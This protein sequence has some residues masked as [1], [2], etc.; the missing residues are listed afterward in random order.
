MNREF[1][2]RSAGEL[3]GIVKRQKW[4]ILLPVLTFT[5]AIGYVVYHLP[6]IY[7]S[8][9]LLTVKPPTISQTLVQALSNEDLSQRL[10][11][12][13]Q[14]V[15]SR[16]SLEPMVTKYDLYKQERASGMPMELIIEKM[17]KA[18]KVDIEDAGNEKVASFR[19]RYRDRDPQATRNVTAE[20]ASKYVNAQVQTQTEIAESTKDL[21]EKQLG[22]KKAAMDDLERQRLDIMTANVATLPESEQGLVAQLSGLRDREANIMKEK[23]SLMNERGRLS[24]SIGSNNRQMALIEDFGQRATNDS[25]RSAAD[26]ENS[27]A[28]GELI[29]KRADINASLDNL[30]KTYKDKHPLV[31]AKQ[32]E[33]LRI[34]EEFENL[35]KSADKRVAVATSTSKDRVDMQKKA[36]ELENQRIQSQIGQIETQLGNKDVEIRQNA[37]EVAALEARINA[38]PGVKVA[39]EGI[40]GQY[41]FAKQ[42]Y[43]EILK[44][45]NEAET[46][47]GVE[48]NAQG[49]TIRVQ[50]PANVPQ[51]PVAP[52]RL[53]WTLMGSALGLFIGLLL[54]GIFE[55]PRFFKIQNIE[56][57]R[58]YTGLPV[59]ASVPPL[60]S[61]AEKSWINRSY[62]MRLGAG[63]AASLGVIPLIIFILQT[64]RLLDRFV[65]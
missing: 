54:A 61:P 58:H 3:I 48:T 40:N 59:L 11:T 42:T 43:D 35:R 26:P 19:I 24:D 22:E 25:A 17:Y 10:Q 53:V 47:V 62:W 12:I 34:N 41:Q 7:E 18:I 50:D 56:D 33:L 8:T 37:A 9:S 38:V 30:L 36:L 29:K 64:T 60:L 55:I 27:V 14:E 49:E 52:K 5:A 13:N 46:V 51:S 57:A 39:L 4:M 2:Q 32:A 65:A 21:F 23:E 28:W 15:L 31:I 6:S 16:S 1:R 63:V 20:L 44:K 45:K